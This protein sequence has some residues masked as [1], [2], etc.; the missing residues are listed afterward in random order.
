MTDNS[1]YNP[2]VLKS[3]PSEISKNPLVIIPKCKL[4]LI[5][6]TMDKKEQEF[7]LIFEIEIYSQ[8]KVVGTKTIARQ[9]IIEEL[10][11]LVYDVFSEHYGMKLKEDK[12]IPNIDTNVD[13]QY[14]R[15]EGTINENKIIFRR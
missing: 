9:S 6:E 13:R 12:S 3:T 15:Y 8:D 11:K 4:Y 7:K 5:D 10:D 2:K 1:E 14:V